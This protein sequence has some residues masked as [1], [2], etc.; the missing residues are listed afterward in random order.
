MARIFKERNLSASLIR[1]I[2]ERTLFSDS[3]S[4]S[5]VP[6]KM[7]ILVKN[8]EEYLQT[9]IPL[10]PLSLYLEFR[11]NGNRSRYEAIY[12]QRRDMALTLALAEAYERKGRFTAKLADTVWAI[13]GFI[14]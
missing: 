6:A 11:D 14:S 5:F 3:V 4:C 12:F 10:L 9:P 13:M 1:G 2:R 7:D 8:A